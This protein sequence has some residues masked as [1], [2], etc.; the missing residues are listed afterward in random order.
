MRRTRARLLAAAVVITTA[1]V[2]SAS[3]DL[4]VTGTHG[5]R[6]IPSAGSD[7]SI[8]LDG[9]GG[10]FDAPTGLDAGGE[11][12][13]DAFPDTGSDAPATI[14]IV[15]NTIAITGPQGNVASGSAMV[16]T[17]DTG[18]LGSASI[19]SPDGSMKLSYCGA[20]TCSWPPE[21]LPYSLQV[22]CVPGSGQT[23]GTLMVSEA[24]GLSMD[25]ASVTCTSTGSGPDG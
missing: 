12:G 10:G 14:N 23:T 7:A 11:G 3:L 8:G 1:G 17:A 4:M 16:V 2:A 15:E 18:M 21:G 6:A 24:G 5:P 25:F 9:G 19:T 22:E 13:F 20:T